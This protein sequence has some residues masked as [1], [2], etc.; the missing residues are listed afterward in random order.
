MRLPRT[1]LS[2]VAKSLSLMLIGSQV[3]AEQTPSADHQSAVSAAIPTDNPPQS[4]TAAEE[5]ATQIN[6]EI[7]AFQRLLDGDSLNQQFPELSSVIPTADAILPS[8][9]QINARALPDSAM[10][11]ND[12]YTKFEQ[13][14][15]YVP[16]YHQAWTQALNQQSL[17]VPIH[18]QSA[19]DRLPSL[20]GRFT[21]WQ[22]DKIE[23][24]FNL[25]FSYDDK[26]SASRLMPVFGSVGQ[27]VTTV[28]PDIDAVSDKEQ[29]TETA[30]A[31]AR[32]TIQYQSQ[33]SYTDNQMMYFDHPLFGIL[34][35]INSADGKPL[36]GVSGSNM[37]P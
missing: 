23:L 21:V 36:K 19:A 31:S 14:D 29:E 26:K 8:E 4:A 33:S 7:I 34:V 15:A 37:T 12:I 9:T 5:Y 25:A 2:L 32:H 20:D 17:A 27:D 13:H 24:N 28:V 16:F 10:Q 22:D 11:L 18:I 1:V 35:L 6:V 3:Y 30:V